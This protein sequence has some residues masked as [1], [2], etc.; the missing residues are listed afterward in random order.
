MM[1]AEVGMP[2]GLRHSAKRGGPTAPKQK[3]KQ[4]TGTTN[5]CDQNES[6]KQTNH[7]DATLG[8]FFSPSSSSPLHKKS[9]EQEGKRKEEIARRNQSIVAAFSFS[10]NCFAVPHENRT[11]EGQPKIRLYSFLSQDFVLGS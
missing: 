11:S 7:K 10:R 2:F 6:V 1:V 9:S 4:K 5:E 8:C 3:Q